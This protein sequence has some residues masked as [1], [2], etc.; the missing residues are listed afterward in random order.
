MLGE[1][2]LCS[3]TG[4][5]S[6]FV[7]LHFGVD[8]LADCQPGLDGRRARSLGQANVG[9]IRHR[10]IN[11]SFS[12]SSASTALCLNFRIAVSESIYVRGLQAVRSR[13]FLVPRPGCHAWLRHCY[14][15]LKL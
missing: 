12:C 13:H 8:P 2:I 5:I 1:T 14:L 11:I 4:C 15:G 10:D 6:N 9:N 3:F 7:I